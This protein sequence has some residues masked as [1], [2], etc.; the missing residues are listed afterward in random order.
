M[1]ADAGVDAA[2][3]RLPWSRLARDGG[4]GLLVDHWYSHA[5]GHVVEAL[6]RCQGYHACDPALPI[7]LVLNGAAPTELASSAPFVERVYAVPYTSFGA[8]V[9]SARRALAR[10]PGELAPENGDAADV[11]VE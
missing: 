3:I 5:V 2:V 7:A 8:P 10:I 9:G 6:R 4:R 11:P 1:A